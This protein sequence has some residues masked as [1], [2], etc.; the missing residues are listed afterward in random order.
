MHI[1]S[2]TKL[3][4][5]IVFLLFAIGFVLPALRERGFGK[6]R[7]LATLSLIAAAVFVARG[8]GLIEF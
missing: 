8:L 1:V 7:Q 5:G 6:Y 2:M 3:V 4:V